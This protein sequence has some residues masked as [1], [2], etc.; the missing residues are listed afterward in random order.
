L[1]KPK[2]LK[3]VGQVRQGRQ[4]CAR[5]AVPVLSRDLAEPGNAG[6]SHWP[7]GTLAAVRLLGIPVPDDDLRRIVSTLLRGDETSRTLAGRIASGLDRRVALLALNADERG[8]LLDVLE[9]TE[10]PALAELRGVLA[11]DTAY[12]G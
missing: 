2:R 7:E 1:N 11:D 12:P 4:E 6:Q 9:E 3:A 5:R 10:R 8:A